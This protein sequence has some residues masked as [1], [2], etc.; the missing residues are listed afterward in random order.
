MIDVTLAHSKVDSEELVDIIDDR[1]LKMQ[2]RYRRDRVLKWS[3]KEP[4]SAFEVDKSGKGRYVR[5]VCS[6]LIQKQGIRTKLRW[7]IKSHPHPVA[8]VERD[9]SEYIMKGMIEDEGY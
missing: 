3:F 9:I 7:G 8:H 4:G 6:K 5:G 2:K 1:E